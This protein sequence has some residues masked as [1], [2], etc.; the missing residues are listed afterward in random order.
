MVPN[1]KQLP[2]VPVLKLRGPVAPAAAVVSGGAGPGAPQSK[3]PLLPTRPTPKLQGQGSSAGETGHRTPTAEMT[4]NR[5]PLA[6]G[7]GTD[8]SHHEH[9]ENISIT[10]R[11]SSTITKNS[12]LL[13]FYV[14]GALEE[15]LDSQDMVLD[16]QY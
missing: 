5:A 7:I 1:G 6:F 14:N 2:A 10:H 8:R 4:V 16:G 13:D 15:H 11:K 3:G 12:P 9:I